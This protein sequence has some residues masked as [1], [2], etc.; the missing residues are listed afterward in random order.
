M[1]RIREIRGRSKPARLRLPRPPPRPVL[2]QRRAPHDRRSRLEG[3]RT[4]LASSEHRTGPTTGRNAAD[5]R[6]RRLAG[7]RR[8]DL[9]LDGH[10]ARQDGEGRDRVRAEA[11]KAPRRPRHRPGSRAGADLGAH[12]HLEGEPRGSE[13]AH[14]R[15]PAGRAQRR[16]QNRNR[17]GASPICST[18]ASA[19]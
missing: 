2:L 8:S 15:I 4:R 7:G 12:P 14:R 17:S 16:R 1:K 18:A 11:R 13:Q 6:L 19:T 10:S 5:A 3:L 9:R